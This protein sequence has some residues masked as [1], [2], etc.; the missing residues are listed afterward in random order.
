MSENNLHS[1]V[2][3]VCQVSSSETVMKLIILMIKYGICESVFILSRKEERKREWKEMRKGRRE[4]S[5]W[6]NQKWQELLFKRWYLSSLSLSSLHFLIFFNSFLE[7]ESGERSEE[8][9]KKLKRGKNRRHVSLKSSLLELFLSFLN[10]LLWIQNYTC[11]LEEKS[12]L[13]PTS[14][15][16]LKS[17]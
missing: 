3:T 17:F 12:Q 11:S 6:I 13:V 5:S 9:E 16:V 10:F 15:L 7:G 14:I 1:P 8:R 4:K 2:I